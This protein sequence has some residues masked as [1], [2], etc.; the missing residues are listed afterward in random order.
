MSHASDT[1]RVKLTVA[2]GY[3]RM[4]SLWELA[5]SS[6]ETCDCVMR[7]DVPN[8]E[9]PVVQPATKNES[10]IVERLLSHDQVDATANA[11]ARTQGLTSQ[12]TTVFQV[13]TLPTV[14]E[15]R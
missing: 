12:V 15:A 7:S 9:N 3:K 1:Y 6:L 2:P 14:K 10:N 11:V 8:G 5:Q 4:W 13:T